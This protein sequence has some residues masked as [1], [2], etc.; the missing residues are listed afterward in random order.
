MKE[1]LTKTFWQGVKKTFYDALENP[2]SEDRDSTAPA[3]AEDTKK[4]SAT[5]EASSSTG[6]S[7]P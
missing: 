5:S 3:P 7:A 6:N 2:P 1:L 4:A